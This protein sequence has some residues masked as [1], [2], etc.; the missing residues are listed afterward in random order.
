MILRIVYDNEA[1][2]GLESDWGFSCLLEAEKKI[3]FDTGAS[4]EILSRNMQQLEIRKEDIEIIALSHEHWDHIGGL[5]AVLH[6]NV[7]VYVPRSFT[8]RTKKSIEERAAGVVE[9]SGPADIVP[10]VHTTG[11][12]E[13]GAG[14]KEQSLGL[15]TKGGEG[16][17]ALTGC[18]HPGLENILAAAERFGEL[19][20]VIGGFHGFSNLELLEKLKMIVPCHCTVHK[21]EI[22]RRYSEKAVW[23]G[24][25]VVI[26]I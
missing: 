25:G 5:D 23:Y 3:L 8:R 19:Y 9:V 22:R 15:D 18:A 16:V 24:A 1:R 4:N 11:E 17:V 7:T 2:E 21:E 14:I 10:G 6:P 26:E 12:L 13:T 20:G